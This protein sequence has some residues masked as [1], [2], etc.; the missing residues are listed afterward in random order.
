MLLQHGSRFFADGHCVQLA[1]PQ[2][3]VQEC[4]PFA[5]DFIR[6]T[7][8]LQ[9]YAAVQTRQQRFYTARRIG[10]NGFRFTENTGIMSAFQQ[11]LGCFCIVTR[12]LYANGSRSNTE[13][14]A[15]APIA[16]KA[17]EVQL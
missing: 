2:Q 13:A 16:A 12:Q 10:I 15:A 1:N 8:A 6:R 5:D 17:R 14:E 4:R 11:L 9:R 7:K 3:D